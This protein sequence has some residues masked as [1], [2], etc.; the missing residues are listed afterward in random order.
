MKTGEQTLFQCIL[1]AIIMGGLLVAIWYQICTIDETLKTLEN[2]IY[3]L[4]L[5]LISISF[6][7]YP[8]I[9]FLHRRE[10]NLKK[11]KGTVL[12]WLVGGVLIL[13]ILMLIITWIK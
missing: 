13:S 11:N 9:T 6:L 10:I 12:L 3:N 7:F 5:V 2:A 1:S 8:I 4:F